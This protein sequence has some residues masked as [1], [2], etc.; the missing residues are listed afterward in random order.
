MHTN[1]NQSRFPRATSRVML[2]AVLTLTLAAPATIAHATTDIT[3]SQEVASAA[4]TEEVSVETTTPAAEPAQAPAEAGAPVEPAPEPQPTPEP[5]PESAPPVEQPAPDSATPAAL[6]LTEDQPAQEPKEEPTAKPTPEDETARPEEVSATPANSE[7]PKPSS[8]GISYL[9]PPNT[10]KYVTFTIEDEAG[11]PVKGGVVSVPGL[12]ERV[13]DANGKATF[14]SVSYGE[15]DYEVTR[16]QGRYDLK[17]VAGG[18]FTVDALTE[19]VSVTME[20]YDGDYDLG[21]FGTI[22]DAATGEPIP[23]A[24]AYVRDVGT[25][26]TYDVDVQND[27]TYRVTALLDRT[28]FIFVTA[29]GYQNFSTTN[30]DPAVG[31]FQRDIEMTQNRNYVTGAVRDPDGVAVVGAQVEFL[32]PATHEVVGSQ[33]VDTNGRYGMFIEPNYS[34]GV[35]TAGEWLVRV[36]PPTDTDLA[37]TFWPGTTNHNDAVTVTLTLGVGVKYLDITMLEDPAANPPIAND[38]AYAVNADTAFVVDN[39]TGGLLGN[40]SGQGSL[41]VV[42]VAGQGLQS[43]KFRVE[44]DLGSKF[45]V[46]V[47]GRFTYIPA[48]GFNGVEAFAY[49]MIDGSGSAAVSAHVV[50][51][52]GEP[53]TPAALDAVDDAYS[54]PS[55]AQAEWSGAQGLLANDIGTSP[56]IVEVQGAASNP[57]DWFEVETDMGGTAQ[58]LAN[59]N[60]RYIPPPGFDGVDTFTYTIEDQTGA[61]SDTATVRITVGDPKNDEELIAADDAYSV[62]MN[63]ALVV[64]NAAGGVLANDSGE[65]ALRVVGLQGTASSTPPFEATSDGGGTITMDAEG[66][67]TYI[68]K[69]GFTGTDTFTYLLDDE[70]DADPA[71]GTVRINVQSNQTEPGDGDDDDDSDNG[72][73]DGTD[74]SGGNNGNSS[75]GGNG[76]SGNGS[77]GNLAVTGSSGFQLA[78]GGAFGAA[79][80]AAAGILLVGRRARRMDES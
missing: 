30:I 28:Y 60:F 71:T 19:N 3:E 22:T 6:A 66:R 59:G 55:G 11:Q 62:K 17:P 29:D 56:F 46:D 61:A 37:T 53:D 24:R 2:G 58:V 23:H 67:F 25:A 18:D 57:P 27:G 73:N 45:T 70:S 79:L 9:V 42:E 64:D 52:V 51:T 36:T 63:T 33:P 32:N 1:S 35:L 20:S 14:M 40:D 7:A 54:T 77:E 43:G 74:S 65:D 44:S 80:L 31:G 39:A 38:D 12:G 10:A 5:A 8:G 50:F 41:V 76:G 75:N 13:I 26:Y 21:F 4:T 68:P 72:G 47:D 15:Y 34:Y 48:P 49:R 78:W 69:T 16:P